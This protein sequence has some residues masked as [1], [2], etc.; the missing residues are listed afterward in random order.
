[1]RA[2]ATGLAESSS[3]DGYVWDVMREREPELINKTRVVYK[4]E[5]L[6]FPSIVGLKSASD[7]K[8]ATG[9]SAAFIDMPS[10]PLGQQILQILELDG[11]TKADP[12]LYDGT[13]QKWLFL[14]A[15]A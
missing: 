7:A 3:I 5:Q 13:L 10:H 4:S 12:S 9:I 11:F 1:M 15:Q 8:L 2:V 6:G 14:K